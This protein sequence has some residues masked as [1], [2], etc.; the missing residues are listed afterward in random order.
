MRNTFLFSIIFA[1]FLLAGCLK[2]PET[3]TSQLPQWYI[4]APANSATYLYGVGEGNSLQSAKNSAL[5]DMAGRLS[6]K[7]GS[8]LNQKTMTSTSNNALGQYQKEVTQNITIDTNKI[9]FSNAQVANSAVMGNSFFILMKVDR[10]EL[11]TLKK[12]EF[13]TMNNQINDVMELSNKQPL[14]EQ[15]YTLE[16]LQPTLLEAKNKAIILKALNNSFN[17][18]FFTQHYAKIETSIIPLKESIKIKIATNV[19]ESFF[20]NE[21]IELLNKNGYKI[22]KEHENVK[23]TLNSSIN[24]SVALGWQIAK[25]NTTISVISNEKIISNTI[26]NSLGRSTSSQKNALIG[27]SK[28]FKNQLLNKGLD[29]I[30][31]NK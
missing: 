22:V 10:K 15:I 9:D 28:Y 5:N 23:I 17:E 6:V 12:Q 25:V 24:Y 1:V 4:N 31:F 2:L 30:L 26:I 18:T 3:Q 21:L 8:S 13:E 29:S 7:V 19:Q 11:Y 20:A 14:L 27:A 16:N